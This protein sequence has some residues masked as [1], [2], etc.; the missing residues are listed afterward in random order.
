MSSSKDKPRVYQGSL[1]WSNVRFGLEFYAKAG[2][3]HDRDAA[4]AHGHE[5]K[6]GYLLADDLGQDVEG[7]DVIVCVIPRRADTGL[8]GR[9]KDD[10]EMVVEDLY[11]GGVA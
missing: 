3:R 2:G 9:I 6:W 1:G 5:E 11:E 8:T 10:L 4:K 7:A